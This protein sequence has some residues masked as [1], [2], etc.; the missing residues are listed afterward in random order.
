MRQTE[1]E[2]NGSFYAHFPWFLLPQSARKASIDDFNNACRNFSSRCFHNSHEFCRG[3]IAATW[4]SH[5]ER[6]RACKQIRI[7]ALAFYSGHTLDS[8]A[9]KSVLSNLRDIAVVTIGLVSVT[10]LLAAPLVCGALWSAL[11]RLAKEYP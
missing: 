5:S 9:V 7:Y 4:G 6:K 8:I 2:A 1:C 11:A 10:L 3:V